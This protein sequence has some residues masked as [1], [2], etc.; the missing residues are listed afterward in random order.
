MHYYNV[1]CLYRYNRLRGVSVPV[2]VRKKSRWIYGLEWSAACCITLYII[3]ITL[4]SLYCAIVG[5]TRLQ[6]NY[7]H[8]RDMAIITRHIRF[9][10]LAEFCVF[11]HSDH[12]PLQGLAFMA[13]SVAGP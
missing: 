13:A 2:S 8:I 4:F 1:H 5:G 3:F 11:N 7:I 6:Y 10:I 12:Q 9:F